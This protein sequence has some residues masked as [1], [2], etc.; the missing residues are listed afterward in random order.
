MKEGRREREIQKRKR[1][2]K[3]KGTAPLGREG[4][5]SGVWVYRTER[6]RS[7]GDRYEWRDQGQVRETRG[8]V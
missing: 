3:K 7:S 1:G 8:R 4:R 5:V 2:R 6:V